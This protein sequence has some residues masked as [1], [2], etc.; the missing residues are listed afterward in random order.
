MGVH[1]VCLLE[2]AIYQFFFIHLTI[3]I[4]FSFVGV[5]KAMQAVQLDSKIKL[6]D[7]PGIVFAGRHSSNEDE[8]SIALKNAVKVQALKDPYTPATAILRRISKQQI[9]ELY[10]IP[11][12]STPE[13]FFALKAKRMGKFKKGGVPN[14]LAAARCVLEDWNSGKIRYVLYT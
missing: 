8:S 12:F 5:T 14:Q 13:E 4:F 11:E 6:L 2:Y 3:T 1:Q 10:D 7:S 9:M